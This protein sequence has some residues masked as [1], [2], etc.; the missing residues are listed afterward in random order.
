MLLTAFLRVRN[1]HGANVNVSV[2][3]SSEIDRP[4]LTTESNVK[5][6]GSQLKMRRK[7]LSF[8]YDSRDL[9]QTMKATLV[10]LLHRASLKYR[11]FNVITRSASKVLVQSIGSL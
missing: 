2:A 7:E 10:R 1:K 3:M 5:Q 11:V 8:L 6:A 4:V 9:Y